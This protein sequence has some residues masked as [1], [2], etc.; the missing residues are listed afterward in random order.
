MARTAIQ[1]NR[2]SYSGSEHRKHKRFSYVWPMRICEL[3]PHTN[4]TKP[5]H[6]AKSRDL[7]Q[8]GM[9]ITSPTSFKINSAALIDLD[10]NR[11][12]LF[13]SIQS[14]L[15]T[16]TKRILTEIVWRRLDLETGLFETGLRFIEEE[17]QAKYAPFI[18]RANE[19]PR[20]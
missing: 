18:G 7:G 15:I 20:S 9:R 3:G 13:I 4:G 10:L 12:I 14:F 8:G 16:P 6:P 1:S 2:N 19:I 5:F 17:E 11:L